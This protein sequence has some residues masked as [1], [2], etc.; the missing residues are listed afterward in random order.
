MSGVRTKTDSTRASRPLDGTKI[1]FLVA[2]GFEQ[3]ELSQPRR[4]LVDAGAETDIVSPDAGRIMAWRGREWGWEFSVDVPLERANAEHYDGLI[5]PGGL[6]SPDSLRVDAS[7]LGFVKRFV[8]AG[9]PIAA[10]GRGPWVLVNA[11]GVRGR[12]LTSHPSI[13]RD[14]ENAGAKWFDAAAVVDANLVTS[15]TPGDL[16]R[17]IEQIVDVLA[18]YRSGGDGAFRKEAS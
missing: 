11:D 2:R 1:A 15:R 12:E 7:A 4:A 9:L 3:D 6:M 10:I 13:R 8:D 14:L 18:R 5:V 17:C 16:P